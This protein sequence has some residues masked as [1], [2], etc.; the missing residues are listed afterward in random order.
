MVASMC[1][2]SGAMLLARRVVRNERC[3]LRD[4]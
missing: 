4:G 3:G 1:L 2:I